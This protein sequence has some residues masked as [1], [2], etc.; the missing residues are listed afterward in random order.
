MFTRREFLIRASAAGGALGL[1]SAGIRPALAETTR[2]I[3]GEAFPAGFTVPAG[4]VWELTAPLSVGGDIVVLGTLRLRPG[5]DLDLEGNSL[6]ILEAGV[7]DAQGTAVAAWGYDIGAFPAGSTI[8]AVPHTAGD[9]DGFRQVTATPAP[10]QYGHRPELLNLTRD[11]VVR[12]GQRVQW[13]SG[14]DENPSAVPSVVRHVAVVDMGGDE[15]GQYPVHFHRQGNGSRGT[16]VEGVAVVR[17]RHHAFVPHGSHGITFRDCVAYDVR[18][19]A[20]WWDPGP[21]HATSDVLYDRCVAARVRP[22]PAIRQRLGAF[23]LGMGSGNTV[24]DCVAVGVT[25]APNSAGYLWPEARVGQWT[26]T[27]NVGHNNDYG[28]FGWQNTPVVPVI[29]GYLGYHNV[30]A[31]IG[32]GAYVNSFQYRDVVLEGNGIGII[33]HALTREGGP[34]DAPLQTWSNVVVR[35]SDE[36]LRTVKHVA[37]S[38]GYPVTFRG[39][40]FDGKIVI[41]DRT[42]SCVLDF[43]DCGLA[44]EDFELRSILPGLRIR[45]QDGGEAFAIDDQGRIS[46]IE[47][48]DERTSD[49]TEPPEDSVDEPEPS[50][51]EP[52]EPAP[53]EDPE[54]T[55]E[56]GSSTA[57]R[58]SRRRRRRSREAPPF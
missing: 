53:E 1:L 8:I 30:R 55:P 54:P 56:Q 46:A 40:S 52:S 2:S 13:N 26:D 12:N 38:E 23:H 11:V 39:C 15:L 45:V 50:E 19:D 4:E 42:N 49:D 37:P 47:P 9:L 58:P 16:L 10:N 29:E 25:G 33:L 20:Y 31:G 22:H 34:A 43:V 36:S 35:G 24:R 51:P 6:W 18:A 32:H 27:G 3:D 41:D 17:G 7:L 48:F 57:P 28:I 44:P 14:H 21:E 5:A